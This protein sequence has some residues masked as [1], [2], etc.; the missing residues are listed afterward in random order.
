MKE[1][2]LDWSHVRRNRL[3]EHVIELEIWGGRERRRQR[4]L[5]QFQKA[6][7]YWKL[8]EEAL[9]RTLW[10]T[11]FGDGCGSVVRQTTD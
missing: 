2:E 4:L 3:L 8:E 10:G 11:G 7:G 6:R 1:G 5:G 9:Y